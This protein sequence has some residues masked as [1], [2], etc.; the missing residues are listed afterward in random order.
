MDIRILMP[1]TRNGVIIALS[2]LIVIFIGASAIIYF[3]WQSE[4][5]TVKEKGRPDLYELSM[6]QLEDGLLVKG[7]VDLLFDAYAETYETVNESRTTEQSKELF[8]ILPIYDSGG[9][10]QINIRYF[11]TLKAT[12][13]DY[14]TLNRIVEQTWS[15]NKE[16]TVFSIEHGEISKIRA[17]IIQY[18]TEW[19]EDPGFYDG[20]SFIDWC[21]QYN[22]LGTADENVIKSRIVPYMVA[23]NGSSIVSL[24]FS[25][26]IVLAL[27]IT[28]LVVIFRGRYLKRK[29]LNPYRSEW[30]DHE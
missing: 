2:V 28:L 21:V 1:K 17:D 22:I 18:L 26:G 23:E 12:S 20:G 27:S 13:I 24:W 16:L 3:P 9:N 6:E 10:G 29:D 14:D 4:Q 15:D 11:M 8:Y 7:K 19:E 30:R 25:C 5:N